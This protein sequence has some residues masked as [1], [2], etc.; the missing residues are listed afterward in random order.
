MP[1]VETTIKIS[2][3]AEGMSLKALEG[4]IA[5]AARKACQRLLLASAQAMEAKALEGVGRPLGRDKQRS[6]QLLTHF[7][8][9]RLQRWQ[10]K[11]RATGGAVRPLDGVLGVQKRQHA[12]PWVAQWAA[13]LAARLSFRQTTLLL[14]ELL[15]DEVDH[16][17]VWRWVQQAGVAI[18]AEEDDQQE[19]VFGRGEEA[20][21]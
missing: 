19:A 5:E 13:R 17:T 20:P 21:S 14:R 1:T 15:E 7:G 9:V 4:A 6:L 16:R 11:E 8:W 2:I 3:P 18:V 10:M 12:S